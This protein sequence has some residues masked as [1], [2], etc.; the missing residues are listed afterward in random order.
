M[1]LNTDY[2]LIVIGG[3][4][5]GLAASQR[6]AEYGARCLVIEREKALGGT[7]VNVGC[8]PKKVMWHAAEIAAVTSGADDYGFKL[9]DVSHNWGALVERRENFIARLNGI[10]DRNLSN[11]DIDRVIGTA[12]FV[13][14]RTVQVGDTQ[15]QAP[16]V[17]IA[18]G[19]E[20]VVPDLPG[21]ELG[22]DSDGFF[23]LTDR[24]RRVAVIGSGYIAIELAGVLNALGSEVDVFS[25][26]D[27]ILR[28]LD[29]MLQLSA[30]KALVDHGVVINTHSNTQGLQQQDDGLHVTCAGAEGSDDDNGTDHGPYD[31]VIWAIGRRPLTADLGLDAAGV[32]ANG[33]GYVEVDPFQETSAP[34]VYAVGDVTGHVELTPVAIAAGRRL[35]DRVF[36][37]MEGRHLDYSNIPT[38]IFAHPPIGTVGLTEPEAIDQFGLDAVKVYISNFNPLYYGVKEHKV[39]ASMKLVCAGDDEKIVGI[40]ITGDGADEILQGFAVAVKMGARKVDFDDTVA[41]HPT[42]AEELV[43]LR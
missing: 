22:I 35:S 8:V 37:G 20:P 33:R 17:I 32:K 42:S 38:V 41:I 43:T 16:H 2:D 11:K 1:T 30:L 5:G 25:R 13:G 12:R 15:Y 27:T 14:D 10:Y 4:S 7:C 24:P 21:A 40:H 36:G 3:G 31:T 9:G 28:S 29:P 23:A 6:A 26:T 39:P 18:T 34:G 19:G